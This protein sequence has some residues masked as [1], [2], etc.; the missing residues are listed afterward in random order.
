MESRYSEDFL[1]RDKALFAKYL[2]IYVNKFNSRIGYGTAGF[3][4]AAEY[5]EHVTTY[6][7]LEISSHLQH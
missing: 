1:N 2:D 7:I 5:L 6:F 4:T 3:R